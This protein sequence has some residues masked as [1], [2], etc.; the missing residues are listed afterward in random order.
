MLSASDCEADARRAG[1]D[2]FLRK[3]RDIALL[4]K[5]VARLLAEKRGAP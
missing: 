5:T 4:V 3:P 2:A 1:A